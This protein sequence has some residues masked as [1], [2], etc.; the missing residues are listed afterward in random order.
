MRSCIL[1]FLSLLA[2]MSVQSQRN[3]SVSGQAL[4]TLA[5]KAVPDVTVTLLLKKDSSLISFSMTDNN[6]RFTIGEIPPGEYKLLFTHVGYHSRTQWL[7]I[8]DTLKKVD[9]G[10]VVMNDRTQVLDEVVVRSEAPPVTLVGD[11]VQYNAG[12]FKT[13]PNAS[14]EQLLKKLPGVQVDREGNIKAQGENVRRVLVDGKEFFGND[15]KMATKNLPA[16]AIDKVQVYDRK[17][18]QSQLTGF[19]DGNSEKTINLKLKEDKKKGSFG[20]VM[21][22]AGTDNRWEGRFNVNS[23]KGA[24]QM[25]VIGMGNNTNAEGFS[26]MD[27]MNFTGELSRMMRGGGG[28][29]NISVSE[30]DPMAAL[31]GNNNR[32]IRTI[33]GGGVNYNNIIGTKAELTSN[34]FYNQFNPRVNTDRQRQYLLPDSSYLYNSSSLT[35]NRTASHRVN[36][37]IDYYI[38]TFHSLKWNPT[39][40]FQDGR[41]K[42][43]S[44]YEQMGSDGRLSNAGYNETSSDNRSFNWNNDLLFRKK[45]RRKGRTLSLSLQTTLNDA[46]AKAEQQ[47]VNQFYDPFGTRYRVDSIDQQSRNNSDLMGYTGKIVYTEPLFRR[48]L[49]EFSL[50]NSF[51]KSTSEKIA[52]DYNGGNGKYDQLND[53]LSNDFENKYSYTNAGFRIRTQQRKYNYSVGLTWQRS[54]LDGTVLSGIKD[55]TIGKTFYNLLPNARFQYNF[56]RYKNMT[57]NYQTTTNQPSARQLQPV[58]DISNP[59]SIYEGNPDLKQEVSHGVRLN[60]TGINPFRNRNLF[61]FVNLTRTD[62]KIVNSDSVF[63][64]GVRKSRPVNTNAVYNINGDINTGQPARFLKGRFEV[65]ASIFYNRGRQFINGQANS[66]GLLSVGPRLSLDMDPHEKLNLRLTA[67]GNINSTRYS[68]QSALNNQFFSQEYELGIDW[69]LPAGFFFSTDFQYTVNNQ[70]SSGFNTQVP[71]WGLSISKQMLKWNRGELKLRI[72]DMLNRNVGVSRNSNQNYIEDT[73]VNTLRRFALLSFTYSLSKTGGAQGG[74]S[75]R[76]I[77]R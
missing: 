15:P 69:Q 77:M 6:G 21:A 30:N 54:S 27:M 32:G 19:D 20:K 65:G 31:L 76:I 55:T 60:Y 75:T 57:V 44:Q 64:N 18:D 16:D 66:I 62:N 4:D 61:V 63:S 14:V 33:W 9:L 8:N 24:R 5:G 56:T 73:R 70:L 38:D 58:P 52:Y 42:S 3:G 40:G 51:T 10:R 48:S 39:V 34:Y 59:L 7:S 12:S 45:F 25:S 23:F 71:L 46:S 74:N 35:D 1:L 28:N 68:L 29:I 67:R 17:S 53:S 2:F 11:T 37:G 49:M 13:A 22:G 26:F 43:T 72:N 47:S 41:N 50:G 36:L